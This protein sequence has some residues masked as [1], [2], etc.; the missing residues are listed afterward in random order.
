MGF[1]LLRAPD[2]PS[3]GRGEIGRCCPECIFAGL[4]G[5]L[6]LSGLGDGDFRAVCRGGG[7]WKLGLKEAEAGLLCKLFRRASCGVL[8]ADMVPG[9]L[10]AGLIGRG[11]LWPSFK[12]GGVDDS[13]RGD[14]C[15]GDIP[16]TYGLAWGV[17]F[18][19]TCR[20]ALRLCPLTG[21]FAAGPEKAPLPSL[22]ASLPS[23]MIDNDLPWPAAGLTALFGPLAGIGAVCGPPLDVPVTT[24]RESAGRCPLTNCALF[25]L[26]TDGALECIGALL[27][28]IDDRLLCDAGWASD[29]PLSCKSPPSPF[30]FSCPGT[31]AMFLKVIIHSISSPA[32]TLGSLHWTKARIFEGAVAGGIFPLQDSLGCYNRR[33]FSDVSALML[34]RAY[35]RII[36]GAFRGR[37]GFERINSG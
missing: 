17:G 21:L 16:P 15:L 6:G 1:K 12:G 22:A 32:Y 18:G 14:G 5:G 30:L 24:L 8:P 4:R 35:I 13:N 36:R 3:G 34:P 7:N 26:A 20:L 29:G 28:A 33:T 19:K 9:L 11:S 27:C 31:S 23:D 2:Q 37:G 25:V 10:L